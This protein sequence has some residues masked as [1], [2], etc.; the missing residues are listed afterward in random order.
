MVDQ[1]G[2]ISTVAGNGLAG[3]ER[4]TAV[5]A[6]RRDLGVPSAVAVG[7]DGS[8]FIVVGGPGASGA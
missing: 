1:N 6:T 8:L 7:P 2:L 4:A 3:P 5:P